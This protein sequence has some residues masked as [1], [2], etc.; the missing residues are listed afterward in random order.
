MTPD[1][2]LVDEPF[3]RARALFSSAMFSVISKVSSLKKKL[4][5]ETQ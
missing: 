3:T 2:E 4:A 5:V 1:R